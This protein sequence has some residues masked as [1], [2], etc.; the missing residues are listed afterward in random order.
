MRRAMYA[1]ATFATLASLSSRA[2]AAD[3]QPELTGFVGSWAQSGGTG[4]WA[5]Q[6]ASNGLH[7]TQTEGAATVADFDCATDGHD[8]NVKVSGHPAK[9][10][11]YFNGPALIELETRG[12][13]VVKRRFA[14][15]GQSLKIT[16]T[17]MTGR[18]Q[19]QEL[20]F[21]RRQSAQNR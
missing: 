15:D 17:Q 7:V 16:V 13:Q 5:I 21:D 4:G 2:V 10:S 12:A 18:V 3:T 8:C 20:Q 19:T 1:F 14:L 6:I 11:M 9:V